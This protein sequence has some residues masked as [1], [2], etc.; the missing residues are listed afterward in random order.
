M[1]TRKRILV[2]L[3]LSVS[4]CAY[5]VD[6]EASLNA[7]LASHASAPQ[8]YESSV[9]FTYSF[10]D[11]RPGRVHSVQIAF[12]HES[13]HAIHHFERN[14]NGIYV[15]IYP[16]GEDLESLTY[17]LVVDGIWTT[18]PYNAGVT[19][20]R[21][22]VA[23]STLEIPQVERAPA[24]VPIVDSDGQ[25]EFR[26]SAP[27]GSTVALVGSFNGW[28]PYMTPMAEESPG[29]FVRQLRLGPGEHL[30]YY[31]I[32]GARYPDML[33]PLIRRHSSGMVVSAVVIPR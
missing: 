1:D 23:L 31:L 8:V 5:A 12:S 14:D 16:L 9:L 32:N 13:Y 7:A 28:D 27:P 11:N 6:S 29:S 15:F 26:V 24:T 20:D 22:G 10:G 21:W 3:S 4:L 33:N 17:R 2:I 25:V 30:Y 18:D 19:T